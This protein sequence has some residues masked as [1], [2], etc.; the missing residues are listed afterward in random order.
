MSA[1]PSPRLRSGRGAWPRPR[2][3]SLAALLALAL[4]GARAGCGPNAEDL[5]S[6]G[7]ELYGQGLFEEARA[8][9]ERAATA[10]RGSASLE[11]RALAGQG[12]CHLRLEALQDAVAD[13]DASLEG[14]DPVADTLAGRAG[15]R[16][17]LGDAAGA[18]DDARSGLAAD[19]AYASFHDDL[20][21][22][23]LTAVALLAS[24]KLGEA[25]EAQ[26]ELDALDPANGL[27][28]ADP[29]TWVVG[30]AVLTTYPAALLLASAAALALE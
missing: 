2:A 13:F 5:L 15:A 21:A 18:R 17:A 11:A 27:E 14:G 10:A 20:D 24:L 8:E 29:A 28:A 30:G 7:W 12:W 3:A 23:D 26:V 1:A 6:R 16:L 22:R 25:G 9:F 19:S 4:G